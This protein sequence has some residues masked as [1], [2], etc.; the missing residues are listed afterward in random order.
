ME[1]IDIHNYIEE[2]L[3]EGIGQSLYDLI[4]DVVRDECRKYPP[5]HYS[6]NNVW[7]EDAVSGL[8]NDF[9]VEKLI[10][11]GWLEHHLYSQESVSGLK[12]ILRRDFRHLLIS[13][14]ERTELSNLFD[15]VK[16]ILQKN[17]QFEPHYPH[18]K[19]HLSLWGL[20]KWKDEGKLVEQRLE[21]IVEAMF[22]V[23]LPPLIRYHPE[24][25]K[26]SHFV[27]TDDLERLLIETF[28]ILKQSVSVSL[29][30]E[31]LRYRLGLLTVNN[32][33]IHEPIKAGGER[34]DLTYEEVIPSLKKENPEIQLE[35]IE[36][37]SLL[38]QELSDRQRMILAYRLSNR[39]NTYE[40]IAIKLD[41]SKSSVQI[42]MNKIEDMIACKDLNQHESEEII[43]QLSELCGKYL[44]KSDGTID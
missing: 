7:D 27:C 38:F 13:K 8:A 35:N 9:I 24:S 6:P 36:I 42:E 17:E 25:E 21:K 14:K 5:S 1:D 15:R 40:D 12:H 16:T 18:A 10:R 11:K 39:K 44:N 26:I 43:H 32:V 22:I 29:I 3:A 30:M 33:S 37:A 34:N 23:E 41:I 31:A 28:E 20:S 19:T 4:T 2:F